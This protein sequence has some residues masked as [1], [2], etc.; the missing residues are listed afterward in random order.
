MSKPAKIL[1]VD[2]DAA[3]REL[4]HAILA[5]NGYSVREAADGEMALESMESE[6]A[7]I[8]LIDILMP[9]KEGLETIIDLK[10][11]FPSLILFAMSA[12]GARKG[13]NFLSIAKK[14]G[15]DGILQKPFTPDE[16]LALVASHGSIETSRGLASYVGR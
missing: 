2:D 12:S 8:V 6:P 14:F 5:Q 15:A 4:A 11:R 16:L 9:R 1:V 13:H 3:V 10:Q 7:D